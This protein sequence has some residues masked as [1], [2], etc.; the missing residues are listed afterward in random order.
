MNLFIVIRTQFEGVHC[1]PACP[2]KDVGFLRNPHRHVFHVTIKWRVRGDDRELEFLRM[3]Q[4]V[5]AYIKE[6]FPYDLGAM[7]CE[8]MAK[9]L[10][11]E[12][13]PEFVSVFEDNENGAELTV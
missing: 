2:F 6:Y 7:S 4:Q 3:K 12:F 1:W 8:Q 11:E 13:D 9:K 10:A 5:D